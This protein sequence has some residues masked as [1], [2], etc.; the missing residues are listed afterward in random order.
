MNV[1]LLAQLAD[2]FLHG[3]NLRH[4][5]GDNDFE[6]KLI[7]KKSSQ[8]TAPNPKFEFK[9]RAPTTEEEKVGEPL[10]SRSCWSVTTMST[11]R[12]AGFC[13]DRFY[14][15]CRCFFSA[16]NLAGSGC[17]SHK[18]APD[19]TDRPPGACAQF[20][21]RQKKRKRYDKRSPT[22]D[23]PSKIRSDYQTR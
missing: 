5:L 9:K 19:A 7:E 16:L 1:G 23:T 15:L 11:D 18:S 10:L 12:F 14:R 4:H 22:F 13:G 17:S 8:K 20:F 6:L 3:L 2:L 21:P